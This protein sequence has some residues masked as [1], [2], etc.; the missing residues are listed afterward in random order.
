MSSGSV[1]KKKK[2]K[3]PHI[4]VLLITIIGILIPTIL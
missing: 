3:M 2:F 1:T 4:Y